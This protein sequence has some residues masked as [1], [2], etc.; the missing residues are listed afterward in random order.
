MTSR[1]CVRRTSAAFERVA[2]AR[3]GRVLRGKWQLERVLG[4]GGMATVYE[5]RHRNGARVA[6]KMLHPALCASETLCERFVREGY[7][8]NRVGHPA[9]PKVLDDDIDDVDGSAFL[10]ME[11]IDG[12]TLEE[13]AAACTTGDR[14]ILRIAREVLEILAVAHD[15]GVVHR[16]IKP[17][18]LIIDGAGRIRVLDFGIARLLE[19]EDPT[20]TTGAPF[21]TPGYIS[22]EQA[23][24]RRDLIGPT[25]DVYLLGATLFTLASGEFVHPVEHAQE[26][27]LAAAMRRARSVATCAPHLS[28][29][30]VALVDRATQRDPRRR[31]QTARAMLREVQ[32]IEAAMNAR[33]SGTSLSTS[34]STSEPKSLPL[35]VTGPTREKKRSGF[36]TVVAAGAIAAALGALG[37]AGGA[38][39]LKRATVEE[40]R[41]PSVGTTTPAATIVEPNATSTVAVGTEEPEPEVIVGEPKSALA[42]ATAAKPSP[43]VHPPPPP[44]HAAGSQKTHKKKPIDVGY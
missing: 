27:V 4:V 6:V 34:V 22:P 35:A 42:A 9:I 37:F 24:G 25:T 3:I 19:D 21:G 36:V 39:R 18:N 38:G 29:D 11:L 33:A 23:L 40:Q 17:D 41:G 31:F 12:V 15:K 20:T 10:V 1:R 44:A 26:L 30:V 8:A 7:V 13:R 43:L 16:D 5:A 2:T 28:K 14:E 32:R